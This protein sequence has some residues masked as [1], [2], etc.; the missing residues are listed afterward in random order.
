MSDEQHPT[1][2]TTMVPSEEMGRQLLSLR[3]DLLVPVLQGM[4][5]EAGR[6]AQSDHEKGRTKLAAALRDLQLNL[7]GSAAF[8]GEVELI[9]EKYIDR[10]KQ[11]SK[12][13]PR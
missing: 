5:K 2:L 9:C 10:E 3:Y 1:E 12:H 8:A 7:R 4:A 11:T 13:A 6:Q